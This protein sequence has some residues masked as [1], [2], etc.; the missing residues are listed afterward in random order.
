MV[1]VPMK[2]TPRHDIVQIDLIG[3]LDPTMSR[4]LDHA[5]RSLDSEHC[6][7]IVIRLEGLEST[8]WAGL[9]DLGAVI[10]KHRENGLDIRADSRLQ[11]VR[12]VLDDFA[13]PTDVP[14]ANG[15]SR[16]RAIIARTPN[17]AHLAA[18]T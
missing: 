6:P 12:S 10:A 1:A 17:H 4:M 15:Q 5:I 3:E 9:C 8:Q 16:R 11:R 7:T 18:S 14:K 13:V 2:Q